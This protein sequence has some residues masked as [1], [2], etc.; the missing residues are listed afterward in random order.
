MPFIRVNLFLRINLFPRINLTID[1]TKNKRR[2][3]VLLFR[4]VEGRK[5]EREED[6]ER[7]KMEKGKNN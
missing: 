1:K 3:E 5:E 4:R 7:S 2:T 6:Q